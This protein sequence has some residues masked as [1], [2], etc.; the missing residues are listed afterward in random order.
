[1]AKKSKKKT[2]EEVYPDEEQGIVPEETEEDTEHEMRTRVKDP[3]V[4]TKEG[5]EVLE[6]E[7]EMEPW[8]EGFSEGA[9]GPGQL[10]KDALTG[11]PLMDPEEVVETMIEGR[12]YR[13]AHEL[14]AQKFREKLKKEKKKLR[15]K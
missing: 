13:F 15:E 7:D 3:D 4:Y 12:L 6:D 11:E 8:E 14:N 10:G 2:E 9:A 5:R 1:M